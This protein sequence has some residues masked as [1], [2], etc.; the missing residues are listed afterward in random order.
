MKEV[1]NKV[2]TFVRAL[3]EAEMIG[4]LVLVTFIKGE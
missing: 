2:V 1:F 3:E 4:L